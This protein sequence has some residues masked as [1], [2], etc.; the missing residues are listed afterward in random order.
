MVVYR[1][2]KTTFAKD[3]TGEGSRLFGGRWNHKFTACIYTSESRALA[4][5][6]YTVNVNINNIPKLLSITSFNIPDDSIVQIKEKDLPVNWQD[7]PIPTSTKDFGTNLIKRQNTFIIK[8]PSCILPEEFNYLINPANN[9][10]NTV[11]I[12]DLKEF[13]YDPRLKE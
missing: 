8:I 6:E 10:I 5:L 1:V 9:L 11:T 4:L 12:I 3:L 2:S 7:S 13:V